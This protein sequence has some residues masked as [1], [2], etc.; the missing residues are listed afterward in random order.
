MSIKDGLLADFDH[1]MGT[2]RR[3]LERLPDDRLSWKPHPRS[4]TLG[5]LATHLSNIP[6]WGGTILNDPSFDLAGAPPPLAE[7]TSRAEILA[8]FDEVCRRTRAMMDRTDAEYQGL[9]T[10]KRGGVQMFSVPRVAAFR[11][12]VLHHVIHHRGQ[13]SVYLRMNEVPIPA[14]YG[15]SADEGGA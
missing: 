11:S 10:L 3:L 7:K 14:I 2:T 4:M 6:N 5:G 1:E 9:W 13:L 8:A 15:P 12:F